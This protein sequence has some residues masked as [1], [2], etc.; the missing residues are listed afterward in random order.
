MMCDVH[1][2]ILF[3]NSIHNNAM[4]S[5]WNNVYHGHHIQLLSIENH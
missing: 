1:I 4:E 3:K 2:G 5:P